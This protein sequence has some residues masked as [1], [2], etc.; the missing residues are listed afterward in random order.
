MEPYFSY[1]EMLEERITSDRHV[2]VACERF[3]A[4]LVVTWNRRKRR[5]RSGGLRRESQRVRDRLR[6][7]RRG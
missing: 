6:K 5:P 3:F 4:R 1:D 7:K 2:R